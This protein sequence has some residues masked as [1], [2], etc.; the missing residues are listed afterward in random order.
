MFINTVLPE[1]AAE[2]LWK[3][4]VEKAAGVGVGQ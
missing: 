4:S 3:V 1:A 2:F